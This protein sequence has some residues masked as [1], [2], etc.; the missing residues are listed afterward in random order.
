M[1]IAGTPVQVRNTDGACLETRDGPYMASALPITGFAVIEAADLAEAVQ[2]FSHVPCAV[3]TALLRYGR[4]NSH[5]DLNDGAREMS[6]FLS[7]DGSIGSGEPVEEWARARSLGAGA[8]S[9]GVRSSL[10]GAA[11]AEERR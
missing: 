7:A 9:P 1:W 2:K 11:F 4:W 5:A 10:S 8:R 6:V 3:R